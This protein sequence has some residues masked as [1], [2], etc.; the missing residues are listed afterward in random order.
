[1]KIEFVSVQFIVLEAE[2]TFSEHNVVKLYGYYFQL[3]CWN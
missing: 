2:I 3:I 1:M